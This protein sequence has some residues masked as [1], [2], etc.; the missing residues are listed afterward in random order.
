MSKGVKKKLYMVYILT[1]LLIKFINNIP[2]H[3][4]FNPIEYVFSLLIK[5][6]LNN[7]VKSISDIIK[8]IIQFKKI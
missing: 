8:V 6:I 7:N 5:N 4:H 2:Y 1:N 3:S